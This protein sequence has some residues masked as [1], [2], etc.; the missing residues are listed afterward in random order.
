[1]LPHLRAQRHGHLLQ[2]SS[3][4]GLGGYPTTGLYSASEFALEG[5]S[6][7]L[8]QE[9]APFGVHVTIVEPGG[10]WTDLYTSMRT[11]TPLPAYA[12]L[13]AELERQWAEGSV[14]SDPRLAVD[15]VLRLV[16]GDDPPLRLVL[17]GLAYDLAVGLA[18]QRV[19]TWARWEPVSR[20]AE[21][22]VPMPTSGT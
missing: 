1:V 9:A 3:L 19:E 6:E 12:Q 15:A 18:R 8:A 22:A 5:L 10:Y 2:M 4:G 21:R 11:A 16:A 17:G 14:D 13:R 20:A 7:A